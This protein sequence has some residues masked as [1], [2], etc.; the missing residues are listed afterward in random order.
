[1][2]QPAEQDS[3]IGLTIGNYEIKH[4]LGEGGMGSVYLAEHP[5]IGKKVALK[6]LHAEFA[7]N[8]DVVSRF[9]T[10][11]KSV[12]DIQHPN[13]VDIVDY[14][15][16]VQD[17]GGDMVYFIM[18]FLAGEA[19]TDLIKR[20]APLA[21]ERALA[22]C[23]QIA[24]AL[25][26][27]HGHNIVHRDLKPDNVILIQRGRQN[28]FVKVLDFGIAKLTGD[29][30]GSRRTRTGIVMGTPAYMSPEQCEGRG[31]VD[32]RTDIYALGIL[33]YE[34]LVGRVPFLGEG[35][36][37]VLVQHLTQK[38]AKP[39]TIRGVIPPHVEAVCMKA[40][41][42]KIERRYPSMDEFMKALADPVGY[43]EANG[44]LEG[45]ANHDLKPGNYQAPPALSTP[46]PSPISPLTPAPGS[47]TPVTP[48]AMQPGTMQPMQVPSPVP[49][50]VPGQT[51]PTPA[52]FQA[53]PTRSGSKVGL[54]AGV[55]AAV[56]V[57]GVGG[58]MLARGGG[59]KSESG[60]DD[61]QEIA[62]GTTDPTVE[63][64]EGDEG[65]PP[66]GAGTPTEG[67]DTDVGTT[68]THTPPAADAAPA[69]PVEPPPPV[70]VTIAVGST[71]DGAEVYVNDEKKPR[72]KTP[73]KFE[74]EQGDKELKITLK[75]RGYQDREQKVVPDK[76]L[77][78]D[79]NL[80]RKR[81]HGDH[82]RTGQQKKPKDDIPR[83]TEILGPTF[84]R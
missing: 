47:L 72:G 1:M 43:V 82:G 56:I 51:S 19:L 38:P 50:P 4:K 18:E 52:P 11:A 22:I 21:P 17:D 76:D 36:G 29:Q 27:S 44:G 28:D 73:F 13:I 77:G 84:G 74:V 33:L 78:L 55:A 42:K 79:Y 57:L 53:G 66:E 12:N 25:A 48:G 65:S 71:P 8:R 14:G 9:F 34:M 64:L 6:V 61:G 75:R 59:G 7:S 5:L 31:N 81:R 80:Q 15:E 58:F 40:L 16:I 26:A 41:E 60:S 68:P 63:G 32:H 24:D 67:G 49:S 62:A 37:E 30:P 45:F 23:I 70:M 35:Y 46:T 69:K 83:D 20:E 3:L 2:E 54:I 10:E 39:T